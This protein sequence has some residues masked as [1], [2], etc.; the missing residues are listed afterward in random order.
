MGIHEVNHCFPLN[1]NN[2]NPYIKSID[3]V[4]KTY[5]EILKNIQFS[6]P[7]YFGPILK[8]F[9]NHCLKEKGQ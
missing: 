1:G 5:N 2:S 7:T 8:Q 3:G 9:E 6:G 4:L